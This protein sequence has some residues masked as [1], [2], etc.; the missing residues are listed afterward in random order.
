MSDTP[1]LCTVCLQHALHLCGAVTS[2]FCGMLTVTHSV[3][4]AFQIS[5]PQEEMVGNLMRQLECLLHEYLSFNWHTSDAVL[6][7]NQDVLQ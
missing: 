1:E 7:S 3:P 2:R 5:T 4:I 6:R